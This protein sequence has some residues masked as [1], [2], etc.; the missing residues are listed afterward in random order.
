MSTNVWWIWMILT[1][2]FF[3]GEIFTAAF[4]VL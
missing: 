1:A 2:L 4:F 3:V